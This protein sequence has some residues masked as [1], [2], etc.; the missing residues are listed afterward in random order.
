MVTAHSVHPPTG[1]RKLM[2]EPL[3]DPSICR[4]PDGY[5][6]LTGTSEPFWAN[7]H[8]QGIRVWR[9]A[10]LFDWEALGA[11]WHCGD[12]PWHKPFIEAGKPLWAPEIHF[13][14]GTFWLTYSMPGWDN[15]AKTSG[16]GLLKSTSGRPEGPYEDMHPNERLGDEIDAS[17]FQ[18]TDGTLYFVWHSGKI[19]PLTL[20]RRELAESPHWIQTTVADS[21]P[22]HHSDLC[23]G[24]FGE[25]SFQH[26]G[27]EGAFLFKREGSYYM[28][29]SEGY[30]G[31]YSCMV[32]VS[33]N[34]Y[35]PYHMRYEAIPYGGHNTIFQDTQGQWW[36]TYFGEPWYER[37]AVVPVS[38]GSDG[39]LI[40][41]RI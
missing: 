19:A 6:Y 15:T 26:I 35:G 2:D 16:S 21:N 31:R 37:P 20:D 39:R 41:G 14:E 34:L 29:C 27:F 30:N 13:F 7:N 5:Y 17:L 28:C 3:R 24:I 40:A 1:L 36:S 18:D 11:V 4:A 38:F 10:D 23:A 8:D 33:T 32:A 22:D 25:S 12:S 9:S